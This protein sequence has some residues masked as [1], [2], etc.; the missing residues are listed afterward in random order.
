MAKIIENIHGRRM[1]AV[2]TDD[3]INIV[4]EYQQ[5]SYNSETYDEIRAALDGKTLYLPEDFW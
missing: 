2:S 4:R 3:I 1:V 5:I